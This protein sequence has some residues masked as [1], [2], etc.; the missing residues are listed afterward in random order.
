M[1][2]CCSVTIQFENAEPVG[3]ALAVAESMIKLHYVPDGTPWKAEA[4]KIPSLSNRYFRFG[5]E[6]L[7]LDPLPEHPNCALKWLRREQSQIVLERCAD[8][9][10]PVEIFRPWDFFTQLCL[11]LSKLFPDTVFTAVC[12]H[13]MTVS[14]TLQLNR[15]VSDRGRMT[16]EEMWSIDEEEDIDENDWSRAGKMTLH[17]TDGVI[18]LPTREKR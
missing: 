14:A 16:Y 10:S 13:E 1:A 15:I 7:K 18:P 3:A 8:I 12:R 5:S 9:Q 17:E 4:E 2:T 11:T 6:A